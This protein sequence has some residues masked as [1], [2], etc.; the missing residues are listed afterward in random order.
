MSARLISKKKGIELSYV[1]DYDVAVETPRTSIAKS[2]ETKNEI[3]ITL[4]IP[5]TD[6]SNKGFQELIKWSE[7]PVQDDDY[8][9]DLAI[10]VNI[11]GKNERTVVFTHARITI[12]IHNK[13]KEDFVIAKITASQKEDKYVGVAFGIKLED[14]YKAAFDRVNN[15]PTLNIILPPMPKNPKK[16]YKDEKEQG[17]EYANTPVDKKIKILPLKIEQKPGTWIYCN[18]PENITE[19]TFEQKFNDVLVSASDTSKTHA[20]MF[21]SY[22]NGFK[23]DATSGYYR[24]AIIDEGSSHAKIEIINAVHHVGSLGDTAKN[25][26]K[27]LYMGESPTSGVP[28]RYKSKDDTVDFSKD[29]DGTTNSNSYYP[30]NIIDNKYYIL[31]EGY[32]SPKDN[33]FTGYIDFKVTKGSVRV[34]DYIV[35]KKESSGKYGAPPTTFY[36]GI[37]TTKLA[38]YSNE[39]IERLK[40]DEGYYSYE[41]PYKDDGKSVIFKER[42]AGDKDVLMINVTDYKDIQEEE[43]HI[44]LMLQLTY[45]VINLKKEIQNMMSAM[46]Q[47]IVEILILMGERKNLLL[48]NWQTSQ[49]HIIQVSQHHGL[50][51]MMDFLMVIID[52]LLVKKIIIMWVTGLLNII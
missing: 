26:L 51:K 11:V 27:S 52:T 33:G 21:Y 42:R 29:Y 34:V 31:Y 1:T 39:P 32:I 30:S 9:A 6:Y 15:P 43:I 25:S 45:L 19:Y 44:A 24:I 46:K 23:H 10:H 16:D 7:L 4:K 17:K 12:D 5:K 36:H 47:E 38:E 40:P 22:G 18:F 49:I 35:R 8:Y 13:T 48:L 28:I 20:R 3:V 37:D 14:T 41:Y 50:I 2:Y